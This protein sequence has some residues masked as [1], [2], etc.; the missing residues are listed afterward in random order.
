MNN[1]KINFI[2]RI[3]I[4]VIGFILFNISSN[5]IAYEITHEANVLNQEQSQEFGK[6]SAVYI[7]ETSAYPP[8]ASA[9][10][11]SLKKCNDTPNECR[12][13]TFFIGA[14]DNGWVYKSKNQTASSQADPNFNETP[15][16]DWRSFERYY[17]YFHPERNSYYMPYYKGAYE[18][19]YLRYKTT[20]TNDYPQSINAVANGLYG[21]IADVTE[22]SHGYHGL[23]NERAAKGG[24]ITKLNINKTP[25]RLNDPNSVIVKTNW[26]KFKIIDGI[27]FSYNIIE[28]ETIKE[29]WD[30]FGSREQNDKLS[31]YMSSVL[32]T[33]AENKGYYSNMDTAFKFWESTVRGAKGWG[34]D[35][36]PSTTGRDANDKIKPASSALNYY[37]N[38][39]VLPKESGTTVYVRH[40]DVTDLSVI[41]TE[42]VESIASTKNLSTEQGKAQ[43]M[44]GF[45]YQYKGDVD[46]K[47]ANI[48][49]GEKFFN[50]KYIRQ[51]NGNN[52]LIG[53][54][55]YGFEAT[56]DENF[57]YWKHLTAS[58][59]EK[60]KNYKC[61]GAVVGKGENILEAVNNRNESLSKIAD[62]RKEAFGTG[63]GNLTEESGGININGT[64]TTVNISKDEKKPVVV[65][66][67]YYEK[68]ETK[69]YVRHVDISNMSQIG[70]ANIP[71]DTTGKL[72]PGKLGI[73]FIVNRENW[74]FSTSNI[75][76]NRSAVAPD[77]SMYTYQEEFLKPIGDTILRVANIKYSTTAGS[78][79]D[80]LSS[81][82]KTSFDA[83]QCVGAAVGKGQRADLAEVTKRDF[84]TEVFNNSKEDFLRIGEY[85][86]SNEKQIYKNGDYT[87]V[88]IAD[89]DYEV[90]VIDFYYMAKPPPP[91]KTVYVRHI[92]VTGKSTFN[93]TTVDTLIQQGKVLKGTGVASIKN[94]Y[95]TITTLN[96]QTGIYVGYQEVYNTQDINQ[97][98]V[99]RDASEDYNCIGTNITQNNSN[100]IANAKTAMNN[101]LNNYSYNT[102]V[103]SQV[104]ATSSS[105][106][107]ILMD[108]YYRSKHQGTPIERKKIGR[109][110]FYT[111][112]GLSE[113]FDSTINNYTD[114][115][116]EKV[117]VIPSN[118]TIT[119][120]T[121]NAY[122]FMLGAIN[123]KKQE[124]ENNE[125]SINYDI[126]QQY[127]VNYKDWSS[128]CSGG[129]KG[130]DN[131]KLVKS[132]C[133]ARYK[134]GTKKVCDSEGKNCKDVDVYST[135]TGSWTAS[136]KTI[137]T[138]VKSTT[139]RYIYNIPY[140]YEYYK[141]KN[142]RMYAISKMQLYDAES[143]YGLPLF[144]GKTHRIMPTNE[145][146]NIFKES[147]TTFT[148]SN[149]SQ[150]PSHTSKK[151]LTTLV[152]E[153]NNEDGD[154]AASVPEGDGNTK[155]KDLFKNYISH[156][157]AA[158]M[159]SMNE[160]GTVSN[161]TSITATFNINNDRISFIDNLS[162]KTAIIT[163]D[164][165]KSISSNTEKSY[166]NSYSRNEFNA[167]KEVN[168][169]NYTY[170]KSKQEVTGTSNLTF[171]YE[172]TD[173]DKVS[174]KTKYPEATQSYY[175]PSGYIT[176]HDAEGNKNYFNIERLSV[177]K[178]RV[179]GKRYSVSDI[180]YDIIKGNSQLNFDVKDTAAING[181]HSWTKTKVDGNG[182]ETFADTE[183]YRKTNQV[184]TLISPGT[185]GKIIWEYGKNN[186]NKNDA[187][188][189]DVFTP[190]SFTTSVKSANKN[191]F[192]NHTN[193]DITNHIQKNSRFTIDIE[194]KNHTKY[195]GISNVLKYVDRYYIKFDF[196]VQDIKIYDAQK[197]SGREYIYTSV[198][199]NTWIGPIYNQYNINTASNGKVYISAVALADPNSALE[200]SVVNQG[201]NEYVVR[202]ISNNAP[203]SLI[204]DVSR[205]IIEA[206]TY[207][208][209]QSNGGNNQNRYQ[210]DKNII[211]YSKYYTQKN[212][213]GDSTYVAE[214]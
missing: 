45:P 15:H 170:S 128:K 107:T 30:V 81:S 100:N 196:D 65:I 115:N 73:A 214:K 83:Y 16:G 161:G 75:T 146:Y 185:L 70:D 111:I 212:I 5:I 211:H 183:M 173:S 82:D 163:G 187:D 208:R 145:Y 197:S 125:Y 209:S 25:L 35:K 76:A 135:C 162:N 167:Q 49:E 27:Y 118:E 154:V 210:G 6:N 176:K 181:D 113:Q 93:A 96:K 117:D 143:N 147:N 164:S 64:W 166:E 141:V 54:I 180:E 144:D 178:E 116:V 9:Y 102:S 188:I 23:Y 103:T 80:N 137:T 10:A 109:L 60:Y 85:K 41:N 204:N 87:S 79:W 105:Y 127:K 21:G 34:W 84:K 121:D 46:R 134:S 31:I 78:Y 201:S 182:G 123:I 99:R 200:E 39:L 43:Y 168:L 198:N 55:K 20:I 153:Y 14:S 192:I 186:N 33:S 47:E 42:T 67:F 205:G 98:T 122:S 152:F 140:N 138:N 13:A 38:I 179:N 22:E 126:T 194:T 3:I 129:C 174:I 136:Y 68:P 51:A 53:N 62:I 110:A 213:F 50:E 101:L 190:V 172:V 191:E 189:V 106:D 202:A 160:S 114:V 199:K 32:R 94:R 95:G 159:N 206:T 26:H 11:E 28:P 155:V 132:Y 1:L 18:R 17:E 19:Y 8:T 63:T 142:L 36:S 177:P 184:T 165:T 133:G 89:N 40:I 149:D 58:D 59:K 112:K 48:T 4:Y 74:E 52:L 150:A 2:K 24:A 44:D 119:A 86:E 77:Y 157:T 104:T 72:V 156:S 195:T 151:L 124:I 171:K 69:V 203:N 12:G 108:F 175:E 7:K 97:I 66:D 120:A 91:I 148:P 158:K 207:I 92:D 71:T 88:V 56:G 193:K 130:T 169:S 139:V 29:I 61:L 131:D 37:D 90:V 57:S